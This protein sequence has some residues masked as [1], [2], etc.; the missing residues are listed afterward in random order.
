MQSKFLPLSLALLFSVFLSGICPAQDKPAPTLKEDAKKIGGTWRT[1]GFRKRNVGEWQCTI[2][3]A[4]SREGLP[5][6][7][8]IN[9][10]RGLTPEG[11]INFTG[12]TGL[13]APVRDNEKGDKQCMTWL[14]PELAK[15]QRLPNDIYY[16]FDGEVA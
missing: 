6:S 1:P 2:Q 5:I 15:K 11:S 3:V 10:E 14:D 13:G 8:T 9:L 16:R 7:L 4:L 12:S